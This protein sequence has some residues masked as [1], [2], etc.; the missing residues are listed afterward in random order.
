MKS[1]KVIIEKLQEISKRYQEGDPM[2]GYDRDA[3]ENDRG[4]IEA[5]GWVI[6]KEIFKS[7]ELKVTKHKMETSE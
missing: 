4:K 3:Q 6:G 7:Q 2:D 5:L 1:E